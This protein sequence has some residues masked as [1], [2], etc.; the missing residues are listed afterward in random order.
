MQSNRGL[1]AGARAED[2]KADTEPLLG[3]RQAGSPS[4][5]VAN[6]GL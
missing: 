5:S 2:E 4:R 1:D 3:E 6:K